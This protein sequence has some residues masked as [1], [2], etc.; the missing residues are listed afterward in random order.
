MTARAGGP[1]RLDEHESDISDHLQEPHLLSELG[2]KPG[3]GSPGD[4]L[5]PRIR[6]RGV[7]DTLHG[8]APSAS[9]TDRKDVSRG[10]LVETMP[11]GV[12]RPSETGPGPRSPH[13]LLPTWTSTALS[14][15]RSICEDVWM[16]AAISTDS[17]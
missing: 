5:R 8:S 17:R 11:D 4:P 12:I 10:T 7:P 2:V 9:V 14:S 1:R 3:P 15:L 16:A 13:R 6:R